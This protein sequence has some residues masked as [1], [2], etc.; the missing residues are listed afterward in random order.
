MSN[1]PAKASQ[2]PKP[3]S[4]CATNAPMLR[5]SNAEENEWLWRSDRRHLLRLRHN[6]PD[7]GKIC[8]VRREIMLGPRFGG[9]HRLLSPQPPV[10]RLTGSLYRTKFQPTALPT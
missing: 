5:A 6:L 9:R 7:N 2:F 4:R 1:P 8:E 10:S 3:L